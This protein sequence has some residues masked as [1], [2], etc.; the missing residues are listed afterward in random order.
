M[1][2]FDL[3][4]VILLDNQLTVH[5]FCNKKLV[6]NIQLSPKPLTLKSNCGE[7]IVYHIANVADYDEPVWFSKKMIANIF[8]LKIMKKQY[9]V[10]YNSE[11][12]SFLVHR[13]AAGLPNLFSRST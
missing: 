10:M 12:E 13:E 3:R 1:Q 5:I 6:G 4:E 2:G 7:L 9:K 11:E 8:A